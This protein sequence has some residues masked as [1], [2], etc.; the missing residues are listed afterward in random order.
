MLTQQTLDKLDT[1]RLTGM[2]EAF[3]QQLAQPATHELAFEERLALLLD[4]EI[5]ARDN[6]RLTR[7]L[8]AARLRLP[9]A[10]PEDIDYR[11]PRGLQRS[12]VAQLA[13]CQWIRQKHNLLLTGPT[14]TGK[15]YLACALGN[16]ACR[17]GLS[18]RYFRVP[19]LLEQLAIAHVDGSY[20]RLMQQLSRTDVL[21]LDDWA[22]AP[23]TAAQ[24]NDLME[25]IEDRHGLRSTLIASQLPVEHWHDYLGEPTLADAI[26]DRLLHNAHR[27]P[28]KGA[29]MRKTQTPE[30]DPS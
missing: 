5:L 4:R 20:P 30:L 7:L 11:Q 14:G 12:Q 1:L 28:L 23:L 10:C 24:R 13:G 9:A 18:S 6:R 17:Q 2:R 29:S 25:L 3:E 21:I 26:L 15:T 8:K 19:R 27:L 16:Q 22:I